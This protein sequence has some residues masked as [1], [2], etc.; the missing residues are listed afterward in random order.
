MTE[1]NFSII[2]SWS[3]VTLEMFDQI[4]QV[5]GTPYEQIPKLLSIL[6]SATEDDIRSVPV[7]LLDS[8]GVSEKL[9]FLSKQPKKMMPAEKITLKGKKYNMSLYPAKWTAGQYL[10]YSSV[11]SADTDRKFAKLIAC[12]CVPEGKKYGEDYDFDEVVNIIYKNMSIEQ[13]LGYA[14]FFA[15][16]LK[17]FAGALRDFSARKKNRLTLRQER[18]LKKKLQAGSTSN[19]T[20]LS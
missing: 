18:K 11:M 6:S 9:S 16:Q 1:L 13:A 8:A 5:T 20:A 19:G 17:S 4:T 12:F 10:D 15:L 14:D 2:T 7:L 3:E